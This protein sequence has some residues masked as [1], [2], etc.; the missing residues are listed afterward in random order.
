MELERTRRGKEGKNVLPANIQGIFHVTD[1]PCALGGLRLAKD[2]K[3]D[4]HLGR[5][6]H[7]Q[8]WHIRHF[9]SYYPLETWLIQAF[10]F[11]KSILQFNP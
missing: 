6:F 4:P 1:S 3:H 7:E 2:H 10:H 5:A 9:M 11:K 8:I